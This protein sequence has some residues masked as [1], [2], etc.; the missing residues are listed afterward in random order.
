MATT[1]L[2]RWS[3]SGPYDRF[4]SV[5]SWLLLVIACALAVAY[6]VYALARDPASST[7]VSSPAARALAAVEA[8][9]GEALDEAL[10]AGAEPS[11]RD[12]EGVPLLQRTMQRRDRELFV[13]LLERGASPSQA[14]DADGRT[15]V[16]LAVHQ[17]DPW[18]LETLIADQADLDAPNARTGLRPLMEAIQA[19]NDTALDRLLSAGA[20]PNATDGSGETALHVAAH[21]NRA[22]YTL[23]VLKAGAD[24][25]AR[26]KSGATFQNYQWMVRE[27]L[28]SERARRERYELRAYLKTRGIELTSQPAAR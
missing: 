24:P 20:D 22:G 9:D 14:N 28:L 25:Y 19:L 18:W 15:A 4:V 11:L 21:T 17:S 13:L 26:N 2:L 23:R 10:V 8:G 12:A 5:R 1:G 6:A 3:G 7:A 27:S 16:H